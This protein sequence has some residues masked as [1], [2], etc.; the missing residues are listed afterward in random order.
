MEG[1]KI[2]SQNKKKKKI[3]WMKIGPEGERTR[4]EDKTR[5]EGRTHSSSSSS[6]NETQDAR[7]WRGET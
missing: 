5:I 4:I 2:A 6:S 1:E 3:S 7:H